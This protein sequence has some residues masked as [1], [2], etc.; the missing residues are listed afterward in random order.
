[1]YKELLNNKKAIRQYKWHI[2]SISDLSLLY[3]VLQWVEPGDTDELYS[4]LQ[5]VEPGNTDE[6]YSVLQWVESGILSITVSWVWCS[7]LLRRDWHTAPC[8]YRSS[9]SAAYTRSERCGA[10]HQWWCHTPTK[11][12]HQWWC[13]IP[14]KLYHYTSM[15]MPYSYNYIIIHQW[16][17]HTPTKLYHYEIQWYSAVLNLSQNRS[18]IFGFLWY[19]F[20]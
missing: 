16:W 14:T 18:V 3:S 9:S 7:R 13:H 5:W 15:V 11:L 1:M 8:H 19:L 12:Y 20:S 10:S 6:L 17:C 2:L 4:V